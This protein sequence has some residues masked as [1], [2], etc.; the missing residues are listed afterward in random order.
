MV[1]AEANTIAYTHRNVYA[2]DMNI[3][4]IEMTEQMSAIIRLW[5]GLTII[6]HN[7]L[8]VH[9]KKWIWSFL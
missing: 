2:T 9:N 7:F 4:N 5:S 8:M 6:F 1:P 3:S